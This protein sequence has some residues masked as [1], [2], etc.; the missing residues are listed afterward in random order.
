MN[1]WLDWLVPIDLS[2]WVVVT[3]I[4]GACLT[5]AVSAAFG[6]GGGDRKSVV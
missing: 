4:V 3:L 2:L 6:I 1:V 5:S